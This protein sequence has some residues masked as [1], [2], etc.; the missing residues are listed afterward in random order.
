MDFAERYY[1][2]IFLSSI[3]LLV[4]C[5]LL[6]LQPGTTVS[7]GVLVAGVVLLGLP[8]GA[9]DPMVA[10]ERFGNRPGF[11]LPLFYGLYATAAVCYTIA[12]WKWPAFGLTSF[13]AIAAYHF[14]S[15]WEGRGSLLSRCAY[16]A[17]IVT[18]PAL[19]HPAQVTAAYEAL[20]FTFPQLLIQVSTV[21]AVSAG[22]V[23]MASA[24][25]RRC[26]TDLIE[27]LCIFAG[28]I[29]L[30]PLL[31][32][33]CYFALLHSPRHLLQTARSVGI[34]HVASIAR[35]T[36]PVLLATLLL[37]AVFFAFLQ[38]RR[39]DDR[40]LYVVFVGLAALTIPH[41]TLEILAERAGEKHGL[42]TESPEA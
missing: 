27:L 30:Q 25:Y 4:F 35:M 22:C 20:G 17:S 15:D 21:V 1:G 26:R 32:F 10:K 38:G 31:F 2:R 19:S 13:L 34:T 14:G 39:V 37:A 12:W 3:C 36:A 40:L 16:G 28:A 23:A 18:L 42:L 41:M 24:A 29:V 33:A 7:L 11:S 9:L 5:S 8:H 6:G